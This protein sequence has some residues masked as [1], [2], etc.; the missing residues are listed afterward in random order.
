MI[1]SATLRV[2]ENGALNTGTPP[3]LA[4]TRST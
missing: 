1:S 4:A 3:R 2:F